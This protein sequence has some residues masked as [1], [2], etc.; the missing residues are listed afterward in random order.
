[1]NLNNWTCNFIVTSIDLD[2]SNKDRTSSNIPY[3]KI[4]KKK[5]KC[6]HLTANSSLT[7]S[8]FLQL[9]VAKFW[10][11]SEFLFFLES[12]P[13]GFHPQNLIRS[14]ILCIAESGRDLSL[15]K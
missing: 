7:K 9:Y 12:H 10:K 3:V 5:M 1:M 11:I 2:L 14:I 4:K 8:I 15:N 6:S 13:T